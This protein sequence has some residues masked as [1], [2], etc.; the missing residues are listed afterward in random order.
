MGVTDLRHVVVGVEQAIAVDVREPDP[1]AR[2]EA[3]RVVVA[4]AERGAEPRPT[5]GEAG[6]ERRG[7]ACGHPARVRERRRERCSAAVIDPGQRREAVLLIG[8]DV[9]DVVRMELGPPCGDE[10]GLRH[11][12]GCEL[13]DQLDFG[14]RERS[15]GVIGGDDLD[16]RVEGIVGSERLVRG[17]D[18]GI[19]HGARV[20]EVAEVDDS[21]DAVVVV[22]VGKEVAGVDVTV[23]RR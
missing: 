4:E 22:T 23:D 13:R 1:V 11:P 19:D 18:C 8:Q 2:I 14:A 12:G 10:D 6:I 20:D 9:R 5:K 21:R 15:Y 3:Y 17:G 7:S 16:E